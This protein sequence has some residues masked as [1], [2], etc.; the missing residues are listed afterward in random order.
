MVTCFYLHIF[1]L[2]P[3]AILLEDLGQLWICP[4]EED[5]QNIEPSEETEGWFTRPDNLGERAMSRKWRLVTHITVTMGTENTRVTDW[6]YYFTLHLILTEKLS[7]SLSWLSS[8]SS[9]TVPSLHLFSS[10]C[11]A[12]LWLLS[13]SWTG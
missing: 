12:T 3:V 10:W 7:S 8:W 5:H 1:F 4:L 6:N 11:D 9:R 13:G 2:D